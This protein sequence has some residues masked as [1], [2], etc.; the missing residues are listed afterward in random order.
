MVHGSGIE[1][2]GTW[3]WNQSS[4]GRWRGGYGWEGPNRE[5]RVKRAGGGGGRWRDR[6]DYRWER[7][8][9]GGDREG[10]RAKEVVEEREK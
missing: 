9:G 6:E 4:T 3:N 1:Q 2:Y 5:D 8:T 10:G 7:P